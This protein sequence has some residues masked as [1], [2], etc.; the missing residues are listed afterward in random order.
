MLTKALASDLPGRFRE[1]IADPLNLLIRRH[2]AAGLVDSGC[3]TLHNG[4]RVPYSGEGAYY[5]EFSEILILNR[6][7][8]EPLEEFAFQSLIPHLP[9]EPVML[10][11][12]AY[13]AHY[14]MWM[15]QARPRAQLYLVE[16]DSNYL[17]A[18]RTNLLRNGYDGRFSR[19]FV[20]HGRF[21][22]D[23]HMATQG[24]ESITLLHSDIQGF[25]LEMLEGAEKALSRHRIH[26]LFISTHSQALHHDVVQA[27][28]GLGYRIEVSSDFDLHSTSY[29]G[30]VMASAPDRPAVFQGTP[31]F[32]GREQIASATPN[33]LLS[34]LAALAVE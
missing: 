29:D 2:P 16:P 31:P 22:V 34:Y 4:N 6:G 25:E 27:L 19:E 5:G 26:H 17:E 30:F 15:A 23:A 11:L 10:E 3:V 18:G 13:W 14:S 33:Q 21:S 24:L 32:M 9:E 8:H 20:G 7:V 12:G 28:D 1:V